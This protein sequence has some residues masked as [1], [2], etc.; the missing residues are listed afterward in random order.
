MSRLVLVIKIWNRPERKTETRNQPITPVR[1]D[2]GAPE[3]L[4]P[5]RRQE[6][7]HG[8]VLGKAPGVAVHSRSPVRSNGPRREFNAHDLGRTNGDLKS[9]VAHD[10][11]TDG[12]RDFLVDWGA[13]QF[14]G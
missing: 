8:Y 13:A 12:L 7:R 3:G 5:E 10:G 11:N 14:G 6:I 2:T 1:S 9:A 4:V